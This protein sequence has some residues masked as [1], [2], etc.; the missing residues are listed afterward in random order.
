MFENMFFVD[1]EHVEGKCFLHKKVVCLFM[2][3]ARFLKVILPGYDFFCSY[4]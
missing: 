4:Y 1:S 2:L 3:Y